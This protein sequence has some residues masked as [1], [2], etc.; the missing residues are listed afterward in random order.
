MNEKLSKLSLDNMERHL[1]E[2]A[3]QLRT[4]SK[5]TSTEYCMPVL[6]LTFL[7]HALQ[8]LFFDIQI[9]ARNGVS[10]LL[11][12]RQKLVEKIRYGI[13]IYRNCMQADFGRMW[14]L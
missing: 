7:R 2:A 4:N 1:W 9:T 11:D 12:L 13:R 5:L 14:F 8:S 10:L 6:G 3:D